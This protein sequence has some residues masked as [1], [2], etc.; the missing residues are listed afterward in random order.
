M[1]NK[2]VKAVTAYVHRKYTTDFWDFAFTVALICAVI[3]Y[4]GYK[5][6][7][8]W[9]YGRYEKAERAFL[10]S[11][12]TYQRAMSHGRPSESQK[13][14]EEWDLVEQDFQMAY[15]QFGRTPLGPVFLMFK[16]QALLAKGKTTDALSAM[17]IAIGKI[18]KSNPLYYLYQTTYALVLLDQQDRQKEGIAVMEKLTGNAKNPFRDMAQYYLGEFYASQGDQAKAHEQWNTVVQQ[19]PQ[20]PSPYVPTSVW[21]SAAQKQLGV[22]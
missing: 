13:A 11:L 4:A 15:D 7:S 17:E 22:A 9:Q 12:E 14:R 20:A 5:G 8:W 1:A 10:E 19:A 2:Y 21:V 16:A 18:K 3:G 6:F